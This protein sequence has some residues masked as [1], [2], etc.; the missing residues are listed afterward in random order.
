M[1][2][3]SSIRCCGYYSF[4]CLFLC[5]YYLRVAI[6]WGWLL[7]EGGI[8]FFGKPAHINNG[9]MG[10]VR[11]I[12]WQLLDAVSSSKCSL[13]VLVWAVETS[14]TLACWSSSEINCIHVHELCILPG[15]SRGD[16]LRAVSIWRNMVPVGCRCDL[17]NKLDKCCLILFTQ[18][19]EM[20]QKS[21]RTISGM[22]NKIKKLEQ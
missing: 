1:Y 5:G 15:D 10:Y 18:L 20:T 17:T 14:R 8:Y 13:S 11:V 19:L 4:R 22:E 7:F 6:I 12:Q 3:I 2:R 9:W 16:C 21:E